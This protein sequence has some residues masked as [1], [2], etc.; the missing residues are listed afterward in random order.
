MLTKPK[1]P[2]R[3]ALEALRLKETLTIEPPHAVKA[4]ITRN[5]L[6][7][8]STLRFEMVVHPKTKART[9]TRIA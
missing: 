5:N 1:S 2:V 7:R 8:N 6:Q 4:H 3:K 9:F